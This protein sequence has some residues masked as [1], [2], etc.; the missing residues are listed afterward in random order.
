MVSGLNRRLMRTI[1]QAQGGLPTRVLAL[2]VGYK[3]LVRLLV[4]AG[5]LEVDTTVSRPVIRAAFKR[6]QT[7]DVPDGEL[8]HDEE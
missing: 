6:P 1:R 4:D 7:T 3:D 5:I 8:G 2:E